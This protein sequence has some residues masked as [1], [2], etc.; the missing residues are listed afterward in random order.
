[1][2]ALVVRES[3]VAPSPEGSKPVPPTGRSFLAVAQVGSMVGGSAARACTIYLNDAGLVQM[4][5]E[6]AGG[7]LHSLAEGTGDT[8]GFLREMSQE[9]LAHQTA[10]PG[11][12]QI[13]EHWAARFAVT[14][15]SPDGQ[16]RAESYESSA[17]PPNIAE[18]IRRLESKVRADH[19]PA[20][21]A[22]LYGRA[23]RQLNFDPEIEKL[24][25]TF[26]ADQLSALPLLASLVTKEM[27]LVRLGASG[28]SAFLAKDLK[29]V[30]G[31]A[32]RVK[33]GDLVY[34]IEAYEL[35][36]P[37]GSCLWKG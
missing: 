27:S 19:L 18:L 33:I 16:Y 10:A 31:R 34:V 1:M 37:E 25:A 17:V 29:I 4:A 12:L 32:A 30:P 11:N 2:T 13:S 36:E 23:R 15:L 26:A 3:G 35:R 6:E 9:T 5:D 20:A 14:S 21:P 7:I 24:H 28:N 22:G 8:A